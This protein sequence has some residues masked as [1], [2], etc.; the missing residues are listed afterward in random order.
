M[1]GNGATSWDW[2]ATPVYAD[3]FGGFHLIPPQLQKD[4]HD[5]NCDFFFRDVR[6]ER[7]PDKCDPIMDKMQEY[8]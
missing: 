4:Y 8:V 2:D 6:P 7:N 1:V 3:T 5:N